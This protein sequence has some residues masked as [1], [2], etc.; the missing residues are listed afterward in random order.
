MN[1]EQI[2]KLAHTHHPIKSP[3]NDDSVSRLLTQALPRGDERVLDLGCGSAEWLLRALT[4]HP[5]VR[6]EGV[7]ISESD[8]AEARD[9]AVRL[10]VGDRLTLHLQKAEDFASPHPFDLILCVGSTH[11]LGGLLPTLEAARKFLAPGG[12]VL[13]G[14]GFWERTPTPEALEVLGDFPDLP[15]LVDQVVTAGWTP[16]QGHTSTRQELDDY[17]WSNWGTLADWAL[18]HPTHPDSPQVLDWSTTRRTEWLRTYRTSWG[19]TTLTLR[20]TPA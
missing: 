2:S 19:F 9:K 7:D 14:D 10:G 12:R 11:A 20:P 17:E 3:L 18:D 15:T 16:V 8:L 4:A 5:D 13:I 6:A 1:R